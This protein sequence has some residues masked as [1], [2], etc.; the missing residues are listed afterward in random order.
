MKYTEQ[1][2]DEIV[3]AARVLV[4][5]WDVQRIHKVEALDA[6]S[7]ALNPKRHRLELPIPT[8]VPARSKGVSEGLEIAARFI[9]KEYCGIPGTGNGGVVAKLCDEV[10]RAADEMKGR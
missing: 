8:C 1:E 5:P 9:L 7:A 3:E 2:R 10:L 4:A 6:L